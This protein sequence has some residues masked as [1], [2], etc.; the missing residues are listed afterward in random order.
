MANKTYSAKATDVERAW[1]LIDLSNKTVGRAATE[2]AKLLRGKHKPMYTPHVDCGDFVVCINA[3]KV[4]FTGNKTEEKRYYRHSGFPGGIRSATASEV[5][6]KY[7]ERIIENAVRGEGHFLRQDQTIDLMRSE[8]E[9]P[10]LA[11]RL[12]PNVWEEAG[13]LDIRGQAGLRVQEILSS[14]YPQYISPDI[15]EKIRERFKIEVP[16]EYM[17]PG[18]TR[19]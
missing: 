10:K 11:D 4:V 3:E 2:I 13:S 9:Y 15:D 1:H 5:L 19:W 8:Y 7:P 14:H 18:N 12:P 6:D 17:Q 16:R